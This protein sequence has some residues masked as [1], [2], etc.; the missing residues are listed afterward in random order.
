MMYWK[1]GRYDFEVKLNAVGL[2]APYNERFALVLSKV[3]VD[4]L[5]ANCD[6][7]EPSVRALLPVDQGSSEA[8]PRVTWNWVYPVIRR[9][10]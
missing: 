5:R 9:V 10:S 2:K 6:Q 1:E 4:R 7:L 3:D 8:I